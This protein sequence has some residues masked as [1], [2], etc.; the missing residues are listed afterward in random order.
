M[1]LF[2][3]TFVFAML[4]AVAAGA[5][6]PLPAEPI[7]ID[8]SPQFVFDQYVVDGL[9]DLVGRTPKTLVNALRPAGNGLVQFYA[10]AMLLGLL[11]F[12][13]ALFL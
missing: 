5:I 9:V 6:D 11:I 2:A 13:G 7:E 3:T 4:H 10:L 12:L 1:R 8:T